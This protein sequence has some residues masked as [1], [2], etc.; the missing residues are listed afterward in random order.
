MCGEFSVSRRSSRSQILA[1]FQDL[2]FKVAQ[3]DPE[4]Y[5]QEGWVKAPIQSFTSKA[6]Q[7]ELFPNKQPLNEDN[8]WYPDIHIPTHRF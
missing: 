2:E 8:H 4:E 1:R 6:S 3:V 5:P 7:G